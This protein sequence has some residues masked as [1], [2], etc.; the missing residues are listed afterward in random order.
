MFILRSRIDV[1]NAF[2]IDFWPSNFQNFLGQN[3]PHPRS[4]LRSFDARALSFPFIF[5]ILSL[6]LVISYVCAKM[7][8][9]VHFEKHN[10][11]AEMP[12]E[13]IS[14][15][16]VFKIFWG[17]THRPRWTLR[18]FGASAAGFTLSCSPADSRMA[19][20]LWF[21]NFIPEFS[22]SFE[23]TEHAPALGSILFKNEPYFAFQ[24]I[25]FQSFRAFGAGALHGNFKS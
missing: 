15:R 20:F 5:E 7:S 13:S 23:K 16:L 21:R 14:G 3:T 19:V 18:A 25:N 11:S 24:K 6:R 10:W 22:K 17:T 2:R 8:G 9:K 4:G 1:W 12:S